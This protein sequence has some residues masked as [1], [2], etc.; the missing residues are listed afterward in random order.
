MM[1][2][3]HGGGNGNGCENVH[4]RP[5]NRYTESLP[6][7]LGHKFIGRPGDGFIEIFAGHLYITAEWYQT[8]AVIG[9]AALEAEKAFA[10]TNAEYVNANAEIFCYD[11]MPEFMD[12]YHGA[13]N[14]NE[15]DAH[16]KI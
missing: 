6:F 7:G 13:E 12:D 4:H 8:Q 14:Y 9:I 1:N 2:H 11:E 10:K 15:Y 16:L 5:R 3:S